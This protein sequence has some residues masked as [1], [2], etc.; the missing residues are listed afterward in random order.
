MND[1]QEQ[2]EF[3]A[4]EIRDLA[5]KLGFYPE[6]ANNRVKVYNGEDELFEY[7]SDTCK[8]IKRGYRDYINRLNTHTYKAYIRVCLQDVARKLKKAEKEEN[9][10]RFTSCQYGNQ[11]WVI[12][13]NDRA[14]MIA[15]FR[16][17]GLAKKKLKELN[18]LLDSQ[19]EIK[20]IIR[21][22][23]SVSEGELEFMSSEIITLIYTKIFKDEK[24]KG[25]IE[26]T[27][28]ELDD[29]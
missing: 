19:D 18:A 7:Q 2:I 14:K 11:A 4:I 15:R 27:I 3:R 24:T 8:F 29:D 9:K 6:L 23:K 26:N 16:S 28:G 17:D 22:N 20:D 21:K 13:D 5:L 1:T 10:A 25:V 12:Y